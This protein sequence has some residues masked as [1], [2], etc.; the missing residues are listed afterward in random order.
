MMN[1]LLVYIHG[2]IIIN[3][4]GGN[5]ER[6]L[7]I[8]NY[9]DIIL[10]DVEYVED[11]L[12]VKLDVRDFKKLKGI[13]KKT[14]VHI[15]IKERYG[16][17]FFLFKNRKRKLFFSG[18]LTSLIL[19]Y[20]LSLYIWQISFEGNYSHTADE[21][22]RFLSE[23]GISSGIKKVECDAENIEKALRNR[24]GDIKWASVEIVGTRLIVHIKEN[25]NE[26]LDEKDGE[27]Y[28][29]VSDK[30]AKILSI[31]TRK[32]TP[33]VKAGDEISAGTVLIGGYYDVMGDYDEYLRTEYVGA[34]GTILA[35]T[36]YELNKT[37][38]REY[39][40]KVYTGNSSNKYSFTLL[41]KNICIDWFMDEYENSDNIEASKQ[42]VI[43]E[44]F[45]LPL[46]F[47]KKTYREYTVN[48]KYYSDEE[49]Y[50]V[51]QEYIDVFL[52]K[53]IEKGIKISQNDVIIEVDEKNI[54]IS[55]KIICEEY[56]GEKRLNE[57]E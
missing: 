57:N 56:I 23:E 48:T 47:A 33:F 20:I 12:Q 21:L 9:N 14:K 24:F 16:L 40:E 52:E 2:W 55:G 46:Y 50:I 15:T 5:Y 42:M 44:N 43:S 13:V 30:D 8:C 34:D 10:R 6:F 18:I 17:P 54:V 3:V 49:A 36:T 27:T 19:I 39:E 37:I 31:V 7:N 29:I 45:Y 4:L 1:K 25:Y 38:S 22:L 53:L 51:G 41:D 11:V 26:V 28:D 35:Q 32:G